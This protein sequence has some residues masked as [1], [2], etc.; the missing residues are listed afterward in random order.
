MKITAPGKATYGRKG[1]GL[2]FNCW[3]NNRTQLRA[4]QP[5]SVIIEGCSKRRNRLSTCSGSP[6]AAAF[7]AQMGKSESPNSGIF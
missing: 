5:K 1:P 3:L 7:V 4:I 2:Q 6:T